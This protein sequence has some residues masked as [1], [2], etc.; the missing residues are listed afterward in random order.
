MHGHSTHH[1]S[2]RSRPLH[3][4][5]WGASG[6]THQRG[7]RS[8]RI[9]QTQ[10]IPSGTTLASPRNLERFGRRAY[11]SKSESTPASNF[12]C[13][14]R[15]RRTTEH[16]Q[17]DGKKGETERRPDRRPSRRR[18][19]QAWMRPAMRAFFAKALKRPSAPKCC[20]ARSAAPAC[21]AG[22]PAHRGSRTPA[23]ETELRIAQS[24][25][26][27]GVL[28]VDLAQQPGEPASGVSSLTTGSGSRPACVHDR[29]PLASSSS[30][31]ASAMRE[32]RKWQ[33]CRS[34]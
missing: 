24:E 17:K 13:A 9:T 8:A 18:G 4:Q 32:S 26:D 23:R 33:P 27:V 19:T 20:P 29:R 12:A 6:C 30:N 5:P 22:R 10:D 25:R 2:C 14:R 21:H 31:G 1:A 7:P 16:R 28:G 11:C 3:H 34:P 15:H